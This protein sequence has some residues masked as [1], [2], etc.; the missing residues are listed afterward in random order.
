MK[1]FRSIASLIVRSYS[2]V[3][4]AYT[5]FLLR[6]TTFQAV[7]IDLSG[8]LPERWIP[9]SPLDLGSRPRMTYRKLLELLDQVAADPKI[10]IVLLRI[11][12]NFLGLARIQELGRALDRIKAADKKLVALIDN[13]GM[14][15][16]LLIA[17]CHQRY[18]VP[19]GVLAP[20]GLNMEVTYLR[21]LLDKA[22]V[23]PDLLVAGRFK[24][25]AETLTR[26]KSS[27]AARE[28]TAG[29]LDDLF[30]QVIA[31]L[32]EALGKT[33]TQIKK[34]IDAAP[35]TAQRAL[36][37]GLVD[38]VAY[39][40]E[41]LKELRLKDDGKLISG[42]R[43]LRITSR[44]NLARARLNQA[45]RLA[46]VYL[47]GAIR[48]GRG[49]PARGRLGAES[50]A[51]IIHRLAK[52]ESIKAV[53]LR[54]SSPGGTV[55]GSDRIR[56]EVE[57]L[58][59]KKPVIVSL[60][61]VAAS[62]GYYVAVAGG[63]ILTERAA[64]TGSIGVIAGKFDISGLYGKLGLTT[65]AY[66]RGA[67]AGI[68]SPY[69]GYTEVERRRMEEI[70]QAVYSDFKKAVAAGRKLSAAEVDRVAEGRVWTGQAAL[71]AKLVDELGGLG[72]AI[73]LAKIKAGRSKDEPVH[74]IEY[75][76]IPSP[77]KMLLMM[78][79]M[80]SLM[81]AA[82]ALEEGLVLAEDLS[83]GP[84]AGLPFKLTIR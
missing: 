8:L 42:I 2:A 32:A 35:Y 52:D 5:G 80:K 33:K 79:T 49:D 57:L 16:S 24:S 13:C 73:G 25:A 43:Y 66:R 31:D 45:P 77:L 36:E 60:G 9:T 26:K 39:R 48:D 72:E 51:R 71:K 7:E 29:L 70:L 53:V 10:E 74:L 55:S 37:A 65:E 44:R 14:R 6:K 17:R 34:L 28:M 18:M 56:R 38:K 68:F 58:S 15:E 75:P 64:L 50:F 27:A 76:R 4:L 12:P 83:A 30:A 54:I 63:Q 81:P 78:P 62:G 1:I 20:T 11:G 23:T 3:Y 61:D 67:A 19:S 47:L 82:A 59:Q 69:R 46:V 22:A 84:Y 41:A 40:D 21:G